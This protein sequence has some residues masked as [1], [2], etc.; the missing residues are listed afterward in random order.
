MVCDMEKRRPLSRRKRLL[1][2]PQSHIKAQREKVESEVIIK[3]V[4]VSV[5]KPLRLMNSTG[6]TCIVES[7]AKGLNRDKT[8][9][10]VRSQTVLGFFNTGNTGR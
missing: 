10:L 4:L 2:E 9:F 7:V 5:L 8:V 6:S 1:P 3:T